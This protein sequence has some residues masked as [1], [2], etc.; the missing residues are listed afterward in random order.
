M[1]ETRRSRK[2]VKWVPQ[3]KCKRG[4]PSHCWRDDIKEAMEA[5][6]LAEEECYRRE[7]SRQGTE[8]L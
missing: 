3:E 6:D 7:E 8:K 1:D 4:Q 2:V 5:R